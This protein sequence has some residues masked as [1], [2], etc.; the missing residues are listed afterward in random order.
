M[1]LTVHISVAGVGGLACE[2]TLIMT[3]P[4]S[5]ATCVYLYELEV[6]SALLR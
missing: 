6:V 5:R 3:W 1:K 2:S 4:F